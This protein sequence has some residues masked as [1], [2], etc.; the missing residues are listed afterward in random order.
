[1][2][3]INEKRTVRDVLDESSERI[4]MMEETMMLKSR[5]CNDTEPEWKVGGTFQKRVCVPISEQG[6]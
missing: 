3:E 1:M 6:A 4:S 5:L 2:K